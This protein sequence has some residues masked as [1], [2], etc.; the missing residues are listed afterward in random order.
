M[1]FP[2]CF[3]L[4]FLLSFIRKTK[5]AWLKNSAVLLHKNLMKPPGLKPCSG[6][7]CFVVG[8]DTLLSQYLSPPRCING[9]RQFDTEGNP[10]MDKHPIQRGSRTFLI[11]LCYGNRDLMG[12]V[13]RMQ[14]VHCNYTKV[15]TVNNNCSLNSVLRTLGF[16]NDSHVLMH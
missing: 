14:T 10:A 15:Y 11:A 13:A 8:Q 7:L 1:N 3:C 2:G 12:L 9:Y 16:C 4:L 5:N 6:T